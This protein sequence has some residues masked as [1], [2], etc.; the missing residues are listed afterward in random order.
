M[1]AENTKARGEKKMPLIGFDVL[2][3]CHSDKIISPFE[4]EKAYVAGLTVVHTFMTPA[5]FIHVNEIEA[6]LAKVNSDKKY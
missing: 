3:M 6:N 4:S 1:E 2:D 5:L